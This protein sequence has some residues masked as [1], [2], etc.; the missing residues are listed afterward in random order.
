MIKLSAFYGLYAPGA[1]TNLFLSAVTVANVLSLDFAVVK[2]IALGLTSVDSGLY[3]V[4]ESSTFLSGLNLMSFVVLKSVA[5]ALRFVNSKLCTL[6]LFAG[7][8]FP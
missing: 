4:G 2:E 1:G 8:D 5:G 7:M 6:R 3:E